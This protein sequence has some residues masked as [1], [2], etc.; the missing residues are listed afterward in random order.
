M[1]VRAGARG[2]IVDNSTLW[3]RV[4]RTLRA[5]ILANALAPG[6]ELQEVGLA[7]R[8]GVS[9]GPIREALGRLASEGLVTIQARRGAFVTGLSKQAFLEAYQVREALEGLAVRLATPRL[10]PKDLR[11]MERLIADMDR[12]AARNDVTRFFEKNA[13]FHRLFVELS[14]NH[15]LQEM[16]RHL[17]SDMGRYTRLSLAL[18]GNMARSVEE[19]RRILEAA[20][21]GDTERSVELLREHVEIPQRQVASLD[22]DAVLALA[23]GQGRA[24][25]IEADASGN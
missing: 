13:E 11:T 5:E 10:T 8:L 24:A 20:R 4:Y 7:E 14:E 19:H 15:R 23:L 6:T 25:H 18:R 16:H 1:G 3:E 9:R 22:D 17:I 12:A 21:A 2:G